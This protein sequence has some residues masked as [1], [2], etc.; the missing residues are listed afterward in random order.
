MYV[1]AEGTLAVKSFNS[2]FEMRILGGD[3]I[4]WNEVKL[5]ILYLRC[6]LWWRRQALR[7]DGAAFNS[8]FEMRRVGEET[9]LFLKPLLS[10]LY[11]RCRARQRY[12]LW[13][14]CRN[15]FQFSI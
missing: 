1:S 2:L 9:G 7:Q 8:L 14:M 4:V 3:S 5:S 12:G 6:S 13:R 15:H 11:L 10:I